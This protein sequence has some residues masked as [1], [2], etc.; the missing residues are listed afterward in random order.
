M[1]GRFPMAETEKYE[2]ASVFEQIKQG[3][4]QSL[5]NV[6]GELTL[7]TTVLVSP[8]P[9]A[10]PMR[11]RS[12][13]RRLKMSQSLFASTLNVSPKLVQ[14]WEQGTRKPGRG[15]LRLIQIIESDPRVI[16][17]LFAPAGKRPAAARAGRDRPRAAR[18]SP[19]A[20]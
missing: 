3:L 20:A 9:S 15:D 12:L 19:A 11:V 8:P 4:E 6:R 2:K 13:R 14:S 7:R 17:A 16:D 18:R 10:S 1:K 5:A